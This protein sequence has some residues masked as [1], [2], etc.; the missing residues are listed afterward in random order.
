MLPS[1]RHHY[2]QALYSSQVRWVSNM[3]VECC[4]PVPSGCNWQ[5]TAFAMSPVL[6]WLVE[7]PAVRALQCKH[8]VC[9]LPVC[10]ILKVLPPSCLPNHHFLFYASHNIHY[11]QSASTREQRLHLRLWFSGCTIDLNSARGCN[12]PC[13]WCNNLYNCHPH[14][15]FDPLIWYTYSPKWPLFHVCAHM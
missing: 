9:L 8:N 3:Y 1:P 4:I 7:L 15:C 14:T 10:F 2:F 13:L 12:I 6:Q 5:F 11:S